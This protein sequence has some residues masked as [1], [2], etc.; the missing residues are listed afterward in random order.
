MNKILVKLYNDKVILNH[1]LIFAKDLAYVLSG[2]DTTVDKTLSEDDLFK[3]ELDAFMRLIETNARRDRV[4]YTL[5]TG[6]LLIN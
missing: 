3:L 4:K 1:G 6:K 2:R 5:A